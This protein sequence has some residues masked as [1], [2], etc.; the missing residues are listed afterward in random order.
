MQT[1]P[2]VI[3]PSLRRGPELGAARRPSAAEFQ[4]GTS[5]GESGRRRHDSRLNAVT[6]S[7]GKP[8]TDWPSRKP[9]AGEPI[10]LMNTES[11]RKWQ[12]RVR[13]GLDKWLA[14]EYP[15]R[16]SRR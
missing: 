5:S 4:K 8:I 12:T 1:A 2:T 11:H 13:D 14:G 16:V 9:A 10:S 6:N 7:G 15:R 3:S